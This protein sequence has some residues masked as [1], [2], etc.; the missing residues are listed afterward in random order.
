[1]D[2]SGLNPKNWGKRKTGAAA[3]ANPPNAPAP[4]SS[5]PKPGASAA[6][7][8][9]ASDDVSL[10]RKPKPQAV[11][12]VAERMVV[13]LK[14]AKSQALSALKSLEGE[15]PDGDKAPAAFAA[16]F[17][18]LE[19]KG[20]EQHKDG[21][22]FVIFYCSYLAALVLD[23]K[24]DWPA[25]AVQFGKLSAALEE[26]QR[27]T[28]RTLLASVLQAALRLSTAEH[29]GKVFT[30]ENLP[31]DKETAAGKETRFFVIV[32]EEV[33]QKG[34]EAFSMLQ[35]SR[36]EPRD[37]ADVFEQAFPAINYIME[38][39]G[40]FERIQAMFYPLYCALLIAGGVPDAQTAKA[41]AV[42]IASVD[43]DASRYSRLAAPGMLAVVL[44]LHSRKQLTTVSFAKK[45][46]SSASSNGQ[47]AAAEKT[48][49]EKK[50]SS[51][52]STGA[53][54]KPPIEDAGP[55]EV[56]LDEADVEDASPD[57]SASDAGSAVHGVKVVPDDEPAETPK[58][59]G[60][61]AAS[62]APADSADTVVQAA[63]VL[64]GCEA[65][66]DPEGMYLQDDDGN[67]V[68]GDGKIVLLKG[69]R[70]DGTFEEG[71]GQTAKPSDA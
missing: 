45:T 25:K 50:A 61:S 15:L 69:Q 13:V 60:D 16:W 28:L 36:R 6:S 27:K 57:A 32:Y 3:E 43:V 12:A 42:A 18:A 1:M 54:I 47:Q 8:V 21:L 37:L 67:S 17:E 58:K 62:S 44:L 24:H 71:H 11:A 68:D 65:P 34:A 51:G 46:E 31:G 23:D 38:N 14:V 53:Q 20:K 56:S 35:A 55:D 70:P 7:A 33:R 64:P 39:D 63:G 29:P 66:F 10:Q 22:L 5:A 26:K 19:L 48:A 41:F 2:L 49:S 59:S 9:A 52:S 40:K 4:S 30:K